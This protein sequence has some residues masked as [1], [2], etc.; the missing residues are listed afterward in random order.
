MQRRSSLF[1]QRPHLQRLQERLSPVFN[2]TVRFDRLQ[3]PHWV[4]GFIYSFLLL[5]LFCWIFIFHL[6]PPAWV[7]AFPSNTCRPEYKILLAL[8]W[9]FPLG[10][11]NVSIGEEDKGLV[12]H[13]K[14]KYP[15]TVR[16][17]SCF[18]VMNLKTT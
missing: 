12:Q 14:A 16:P 8:G 9:V 13:E 6:Y 4:L 15:E 17:A 7:K 2:V 18:K 11:G 3:H 10:P 1:P 5:L